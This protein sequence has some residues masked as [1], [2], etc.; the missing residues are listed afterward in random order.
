MNGSSRS[1]I[2]TVTASGDNIIVNGLANTMRI[3]N[4]DISDD[5]VVRGG[6]GADV[7][8]LGTVPSQFR[9]PHAGWRRR[10]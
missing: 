3:T 2:I 1:E 6:G 4:T 9:E 8:R 10:Q 5:I 7:I